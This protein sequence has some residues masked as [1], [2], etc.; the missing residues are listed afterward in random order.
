MGNPDWTACLTLWLLQYQGFALVAQSDPD[1]SVRARFEE[2]LTE[3]K[4]VMDAILAKM[5]RQSLR[6][7]S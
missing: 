2:T 6:K 5:R 4:R 1:P 7:A 3:R